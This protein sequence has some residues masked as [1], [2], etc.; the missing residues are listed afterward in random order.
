VYGMCLLNVVP[1]G[2]TPVVS[3]NDARSMGY[4]L[5]ICPGVLLRAV[6]PAA[7]A[8]LQALKQSGLP[9]GSGSEVAIADS[10]RRFGAGE[11]DA[12]RREYAVREA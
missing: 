6:V 2:K 3:H 1:G 11:W 5:A 12:L 4:R 9:T 8:A 10:F 7:D